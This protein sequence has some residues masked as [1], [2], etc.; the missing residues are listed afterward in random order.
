MCQSWSFVGYFNEVKSQ[1]ESRYQDIEVI[2]ENYPLKN[3][4]KT[5]YNIMIGIQISAIVLILLSDLI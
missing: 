4:R 2:P 3:P 5:I 1:L